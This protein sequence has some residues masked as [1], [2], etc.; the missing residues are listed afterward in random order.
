MKTEDPTPNPLWTTFDRSKVRE[1]FQLLEDK[2]HILLSSHIRADADSVGSQLGLAYLLESLGNSVEIANHGG[3]DRH[4]KWLPRADE[5]QDGPSRLSGQHELVVSLDCANRERLADMRRV[6]SEDMPVLNIDH[7]RTNSQFGDVNWVEPEASS[8]GEMIYALWSHSSFEVDVEPATC[9]Y[10]AL[11]ADTGQFSFPQTSH[12][13]HYVGGRLLETGVDSYCVNKKLYQN[14]EREELKLMGYIIQHLEQSV[15]GELG[16]AVLDEEAYR[17]CGMEPWES[18]PFVQVLMRLREVE[19][20]L[21]LRRLI[22]PEVGGDPEKGPIKGSIR[23]RGK[24]DVSKLAGL[25]GGGGHQQA[26]GFLI[27][28][29]NG[30]GIQEV[31]E[32]VIDRIEEAMK[33]NENMLQE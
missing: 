20:G 25:F 32:R 12:L 28:Q 1:I 13:S 31:E 5:I 8:T 2:R 24:Y 10:T 21:L 14:L 11:V 15:G 17:Q 30:E 7:H 23:S 3:I 4:Y 6:M 18:Q 29:E 22:S 26:A 16:W 27:E 9:L 19:V 33:N